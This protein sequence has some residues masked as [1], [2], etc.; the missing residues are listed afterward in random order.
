MDDLIAP[1]HITPDFIPVPGSTVVCVD[2]DGEAVL[3][4]EDDGG[5]DRLDPI[6][7]AV[8]SCLDGKTSIAQLADDLANVYDADR[9]VIER[10]VLELMRQLGH[11]R[12]L[13][14]VR[15]DDGEPGSRG[16]DGD[17]FDQT[18]GRG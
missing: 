18:R 10:D 16:A 1:E 11:R 4:D 15:A 2:L 17:S 8:W 5:L 12:L 9:A 3:F 14:G 13:E 6:G 7:A